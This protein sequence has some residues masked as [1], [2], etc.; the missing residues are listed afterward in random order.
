MATD[1]SLGRV[2]TDLRGGGMFSDHFITNLLPDSTVKDVENRSAFGE[3]L[4][5]NVYVWWRLF[6]TGWGHWPS[7]GWPMAPFLRHPIL[8]I[9]VFTSTEQTYMHKFYTELQQ[10]SKLSSKLQKQ[11]N[12]T[13]SIFMI[14]E[15][16]RPST[17]RLR[18]RYTA[19][20]AFV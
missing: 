7:S 11:R 9:Q 2:A 19:V 1:I 16:S 13:H 10:S 20:A 12:Y 3:V 17:F 6:G 18:D 5:G 8:Y 14:D 15:L 4:V